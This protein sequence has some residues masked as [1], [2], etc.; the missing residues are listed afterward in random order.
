MAQDS[1]QPQVL[2]EVHGESGR[3]PAA[4]RLAIVS[5]LDIRPLGIQ[6]LL[7]KQAVFDL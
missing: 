6:Q 1:V 7:V 2:P 3:K 5:R 4:A